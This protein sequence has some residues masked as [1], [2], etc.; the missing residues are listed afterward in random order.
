MNVSQWWQDDINYVRQ[1]R[2][3]VYSD[4]TVYECKK[5]NDSIVDVRMAT[6]NDKTV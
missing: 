4:K 5:E 1:L 2:Q 6:Y 3:T